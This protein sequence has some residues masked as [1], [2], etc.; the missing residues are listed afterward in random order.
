MVAV[1]S[2][3]C[4]PARLLASAALAALIALPACS[5]RPLP[6]PA[7]GPHT[8]P[9][10]SWPEISTPPPAVEAEEIGPRP[11]PAFVWIDG[12]WAYQPLS[13]RWVWEQGRWCVPPPGSVYYAP[14]QITQERYLTGKRVTRWNDRLQRYEEVDNQEDRW[15]WARGHFYRQSPDGQIVPSPLDPLCSSRSGFSGTPGR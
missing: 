10:E 5:A 14:A 8:A 11:G 12:Q 1:G 13:H 3:A 15:R 4:W 7:V 9:I 2:G 6:L